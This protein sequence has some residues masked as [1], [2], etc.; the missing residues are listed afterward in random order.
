MKAIQGLAR[1]ETVEIC[2]TLIKRNPRQHVFYLSFS[3]PDGEVALHTVSNYTIILILESIK[4][5]F[6]LDAKL[7][8]DTK[9]NE[10][11]KDF[12]QDAIHAVKTNNI[13][14]MEPVFSFLLDFQYLQLHDLS[15]ITAEWQ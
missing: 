3:P 10:N 6:D 1:P 13:I 7:T 14:A 9:K 11:K 15:M 8:I 12:L 2:K 4:Q 5:D